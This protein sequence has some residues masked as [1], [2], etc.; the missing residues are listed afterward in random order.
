MS[1]QPDFTR[2]KFGPLREEKTFRNALA[3]RIVK[4]V[5][6]HRRTPYL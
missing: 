4:G 5:P 6:A 3:H 1:S 2:K